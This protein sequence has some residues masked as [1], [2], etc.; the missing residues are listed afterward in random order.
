MQCGPRN[1][2]NCKENVPF[3]SIV[4]YVIIQIE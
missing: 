4:I 2:R 3:S 1:C